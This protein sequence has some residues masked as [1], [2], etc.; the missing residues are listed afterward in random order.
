MFAMMLTA[1]S[2]GRMARAYPVAGSAYTY[3]A[4]EIHPA[5][6]YVTGWS[7]LL[8]YVVNPVICTI[9]CSKAMMGLFPMTGYA[10]WAVF[11]AVLFTLM[12]M[13]GIQATARTNQMLTVAMGVVI[14]WMLAAAVRY[15]TGMP[16]LTAVDFTRPFYDPERFSWMSISNGASIAVLTYIGFDGISTLS[17]E[18]KNP[19]RNILLGTVGTCLIKIGRASCRER[20]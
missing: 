7:M 20:V 15:L 8:D 19:R 14:V 3:V 16:Q 17:E 12:N 11:F 5:L 13:R 6:G 1:L 2:Y 10:F 4:R 9:W 18:V